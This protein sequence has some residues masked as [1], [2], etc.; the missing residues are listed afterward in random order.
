MMMILIVDVTKKVE[1]GKEEAIGTHHRYYKHITRLCAWP[2]SL[3]DEM[4]HNST[5]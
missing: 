2:N 5:T 3:E 4:Q 1:Q